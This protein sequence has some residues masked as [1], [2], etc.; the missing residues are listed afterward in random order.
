MALTL[1]ENGYVYIAQPPL[2]KVKRGRKEEYI[3]D[4]KAAIVQSHF[5]WYKEYAPT[6]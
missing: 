4:E 1:I 2:Y 5:T 3:K 6:T